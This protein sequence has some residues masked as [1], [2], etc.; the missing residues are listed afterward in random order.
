MNAELHRIALH[1][2]TLNGIEKKNHT[3][4]YR[5]EAFQVENHERVPAI[6]QPTTIHFHSHKNQYPTNLNWSFE[7]T[8][9]NSTRLSIMVFTEVN[10]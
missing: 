5:M 10:K 6:Q 3:V 1:C 7:S 8:S 4:H 2:I 9:S